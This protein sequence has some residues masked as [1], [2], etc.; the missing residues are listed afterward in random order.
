LEAAYLG[1]T[2]ATIVTILSLQRI[3]IGAGVM[4]QPHLLPAHPE[5]LREG[6]AWLSAPSEDTQRR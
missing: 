3:I 1:Q 5:G 6:T 4:H 2:L